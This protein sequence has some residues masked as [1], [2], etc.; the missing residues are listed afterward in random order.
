MDWS[1]AVARDVARLWAAMRNGDV[2]VNPALL[3]QFTTVS[4]ADLKKQ[5]FHYWVAFPALK[6]GL[7]FT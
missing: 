1:A 7:I 4:F 3:Y 2:L 5:H 6:V